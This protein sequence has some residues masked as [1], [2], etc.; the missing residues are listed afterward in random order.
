MV[1]A[2]RLFTE[3]SPAAVAGG[4]TA[5]GFRS[6]TV[7]HGVDAYR[8]VYRTVDA[9][10]R[11]TTASG[12][13][14]LPHGRFGRLRPVSFTHGTELHR[15]DAPSADP[16]GFTGAAP[17]TYAAAGFAGVAPDYLGLGSGPGTHPWMDLPS[18]T[19]AALDMLRAARRFAPLTGR[20]LGRE[21][22]VTG[23]S[24]GA[25]A[26]LGLGRALHGGAD[27]WFRLGALAP[28]SGAY[29]LRDAE[30]PALLSGR[31]PPPNSVFFTAY[32][33]VS[34]DRVYD[35][36]ATPGEVF[37]A[38]YARTVEDLFDGTHTWEELAR[39][40]PGT[41]GELLTPHGRDLLSRPRGG[42]AEA[43]RAAD[44][45]CTGWAPRAP[46][47]LYLTGGDEQAVEA[48]TAHCRAA[49]RA[50]GTSAG[51]VDLGPVEWRGSRH[52]GSHVAALSEIVRWF[53]S[54]R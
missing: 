30:I 17:V 50:S 54:L 44:R 33:L 20:L 25:P 31:V 47:R 21:V 13:L 1:R 6:D 41:L 22:L 24:Q 45:S 2:E 42:L 49:F 32:A 11:P 9:H 43:L 39:A 15:A 36:Y 19:T 16:R 23:F 35:V 18:E 8:L 38:P 51:V 40:T 12:L 29:A 37:R 48:N 14:T 3:P 46:L 34:F 27:R 7:R 10:G 5:L 28:V 4:L 53:R 26:A 52:F